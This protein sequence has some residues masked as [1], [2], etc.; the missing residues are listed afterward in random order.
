MALGNRLKPPP[1]PAAPAGDEQSQQAEQSWFSRRANS[2]AS[3]AA[4]KNDECRTTAYRMRLPS[5]G[6]WRM[7]ATAKE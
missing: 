1:A 7:D 6:S 2:P 5:A 3:P 4:G